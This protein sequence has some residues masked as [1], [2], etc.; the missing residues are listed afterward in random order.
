MKK[1]IYGVLAATM[2][3]NAGAA[4]AGVTQDPHAGDRGRFAK[5]ARS[6]LGS[7]WM[8]A[9]K[10][11]EMAKKCSKYIPKQAIIAQGE[12]KGK[13]WGEAFPKSWFVNPNQNKGKKTETGDIFL[14]YSKGDHKFKWQ[15]KFNN[16]K[17]PGSYNHHRDGYYDVMRTKH[18][19]ESD[20]VDYVL[21]AEGGI[22]KEAMTADAYGK[23]EQL[24]N[25]VYADNDVRS[26]INNPDCI[27]VGK[28]INE[29]YKQLTQQQRDLMIFNAEGCK[30]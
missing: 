30:V 19:H 14:N 6:C 26:K 20:I 8:A 1:V 29:K 24:L 17:V 13:A 22:A 5:E 7:S 4:V 18:I 15:I 3:L 28:A 27:K 23:Y 11:V 10:T 12:G 21:F 16:D 2:M 9:D 25:K